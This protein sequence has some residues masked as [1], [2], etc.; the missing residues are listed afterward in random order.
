MMSGIYW[1]LM[2]I[3]VRFVILLSVII[4]GKG[5]ELSV[6][7]LDENVCMYFYLENCCVMENF[8][9]INGIKIIVLLGFV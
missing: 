1:L 7:I 4:I 3:N 5:V 6:Y 9:D 2:F 8:V